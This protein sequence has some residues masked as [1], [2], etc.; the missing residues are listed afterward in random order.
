MKGLEPYSLFMP[1]GSCLM[2]LVLPWHGVL[3]D[4]ADMLTYVFRCMLGM[5]EWNSKRPSRLPSPAESRLSTGAVS[6]REVV[7]QTCM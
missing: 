7:D 1:M 4:S 6:R 2:R 3:F 5:G